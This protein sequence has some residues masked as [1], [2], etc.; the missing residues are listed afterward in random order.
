MRPRILIPLIV[1]ALAVAYF[2]YLRKNVAEASLILVNGVVYTVDDSRPVAEAI[3]LRG[4]EI[5]G[6]GTNDEIRRQFRADSVIDLGGKPVYPG[7]V[8]SHAH[9]EGLGVFLLN[10]DLTGTGSIEEIQ[11]H[12]AGRVKE[13]KPGVWLRGRG[14]DQNRWKNKAFPDHRSLDSV[15]G[16]VPVYL[17][18]VDG[19]A[20]WVNKKVLEIAGITRE[21]PD[22]PGGRIV[23]DVSGEPT[24]VFVDDAVDLLSATLPDPTPEERTE[25]VLAAVNSCIRLGLTGVHD[26]GV[27]LEILSIYRQLIEQSRFPL[28]V[29]AAIGGDGEAWRHYEKS[30]PELGGA[31]DHLTVR[32]L[33]LYADGALGSYGAALIEPYSDDPANRGLTLTPTDSIRYLARLALEKGFQLCVH[34][35]GDRANHIVLNVYEEV[36]KEHPEEAE[37]ARFRIEHAQ[38]LAPDDIPRFQDIGVIPAM[39]PTH[40]TSDMYWAETRLGPERTKGCYAWRSLIDSG[41]KVPAGSDFP[42]ESNNPLWG[43][44]AA[45][46]RQDH[47]GWPS[48]GW[49]AEQRMTR[50]EALKSFTLWAAYAG[51]E[52]KRRGSVET[53]KI[54]DLVVLSDD[55]MNVEPSRI[56]RTTVELTI[57][58]GEIV[59]GGGTFAGR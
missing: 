9:L 19:H 22:P 36:F 46:T 59:Y 31:G 6:V 20:V 39:Q 33:K 27:D 40:C 28:R 7:F 48:G 11:R 34:A 52:E 54:A 53:G 42:V 47:S 45:I 2:M 14:W 29:Y 13:T 17:N 5:I 21:T 32:A 4:D 25:A 1:V 3:A 41:V 23:R 26:M 50:D 49:H 44:Y 57:I 43:F 24:G 10:L 30:G 16:D 18:R 55:I 51:F 56:L 58:G 8:D 38:V 37:N 12:I 35:I 15:S